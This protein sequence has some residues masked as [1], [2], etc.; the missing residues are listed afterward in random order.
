MT[1]FDAI[2]NVLV[3][4][5]YGIGDV[6]METPVLEA[7]H[8]RIPDAHITCLG[9]PPAVELLQGDPHVDRVESIARWRLTHRWDEGTAESRAEIERWLEEREFDL[10]LDAR[11]AAV[12]VGRA[13]W[14]RGIRTL[15]ADERVEAESIAA[16]EGGVAAIRAAVHAGWGLEIA[17]SGRPRLH[18]SERERLA[19]ASFLIAAGMRPGE[20]PP[21]AISPVA[22]LPMKRWPLERFAHIADRLAE[23]S[24]RRVLLIS[25]PQEDAGDAVASSMRHV[26]RV[27]RI[28][29]V[30]LRRVASLLARCGVLVCND[31]GVMHMAAAVGTPVVGVFGPTSPDIFLPPTPDATGLVGRDIACPHRN[32]R[33]LHPPGCW[34]SS[35]C[36]I[37]EQSCITRVSTE[38]V[39]AAARAALVTTGSR[40]RRGPPE[41]GPDRDPAAA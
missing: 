24:G 41:R 12:A 16:G 33:S 5:R 23:E 9:A 34:T 10:V 17:A 2:R 29:A 25:G 15:E 13:V 21:I 6:V 40:I 39:L 35:H 20:M 26:D 38:S 36:L 22:S 31:T 30:H 27:I 37:A 32:T 18:L 28:G 7:L 8:R 11:C 4:L 19:A 3:C 1:Q 14:A